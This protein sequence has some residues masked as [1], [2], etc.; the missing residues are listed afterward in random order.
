MV[1]FE[2]AVNLQS[3]HAAL[4]EVWSYP[5][6]TEIPYFHEAAR[7]VSERKR[8]L[9]K[10]MLWRAG[11]CIRRGPGV[12]VGEGRVSFRVL[13]ELAGLRVQRTELKT[14]DQFDAMSDEELRQYVYGKD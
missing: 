7:V 4:I 6:E 5:A 9:H 12:L 8:R 11:Y 3:R 2:L 14:V 10:L 13:D 1:G